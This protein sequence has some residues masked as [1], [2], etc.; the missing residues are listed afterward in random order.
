MV[1]V[2][3]E[4]LVTDYQVAFVRDGIHV[5]SGVTIGVSLIEAL[6]QIVR[7]L[8]DA[9]VVQFIAGVVF[10]NVLPVSGRIVHAHIDTV[11]TACQGMLRSAD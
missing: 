9:V 1:H 6:I 5:P 2:T 3:D 7:F 10:G 4:E 11:D 8:G